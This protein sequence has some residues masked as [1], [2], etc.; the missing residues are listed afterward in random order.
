MTREEIRVVVFILTAL[1][2][3]AL[4][5]HW[6]MLHPVP[7]PPPAVEASRKWAK[8]PYVF[9]NEK[10]LENRARAVEEEFPTAAPK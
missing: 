2:V 4:Y 9:K 8:P 3:G 6:R 1:I 5:R 10:E 7:P